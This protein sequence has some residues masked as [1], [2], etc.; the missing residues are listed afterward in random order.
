MV[1]GNYHVIVMNSPEQRVF[2]I[3]RTINISQTHS[4]F[5]ELEETVKQLGLKRSGAMQQMYLGEEFSY[6]SMEVEAQMEVLGGA[7][8]IRVIPAGTYAAVTHTGP[9]ETIKYAYDAINCWLQE[10]PE[11]RVCGAPIERYLKDEN[12]VD[13]AEDLETGI[14]FPVALLQEKQ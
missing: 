8:G 9:Y 3:R 2:C 6:D 7:P 10:H 14:L 12:M 13:N 4:L 1:Q 5:T 11:Y